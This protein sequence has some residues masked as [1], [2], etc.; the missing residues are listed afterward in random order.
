MVDFPSFFLCLP[1]PIRRNRAPPWMSAERIPSW[2][3]PWRGRPGAKK[4]RSLPRSPGGV[5]G[6]MTVNND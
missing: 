6:T 4:K 2:R 1:D 5:H 3:G